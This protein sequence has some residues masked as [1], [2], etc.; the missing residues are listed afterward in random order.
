MTSR[1][2]PPPASLWADLGEAARRSAQYGIDPTSPQLTSFSDLSEA[3]ERLANLSDPLLQPTLQQILDANI[4]VVL[5]DH[6]GNIALCAA[7]SRPV[8]NAMDT[9]ALAVGYS[10]AEDKVGTNGV[11]TSLATKQPAMVVGG[12]HYLEAFKRFS[13]AHAP[14]FDPVSRRVI[15]SVGLVCPVAETN[16]FLLPTAFQL[17]QSIQEQLL[18]E[19]SPDERVLLQSF[20]R[21]RRNRTVA[22]LAINRKTWIATPT[23]QA[24]LADHDHVS[25]WSHLEQALETR[26]PVEIAG[27]E[28]RLIQLHVR[29]VVGHEAVVLGVVE[30]EDS[31]RVECEAFARQGELPNMVGQSAAWQHV[32][33][34]SHSASRLRQPL[35]ITGEFG[36][37]RSTVAKAIAHI[38]G[39][40]YDAF[41]AS[42]VAIE[43]ATAWLARIAQALAQPQVVIIR[44]LDLLEDSAL[45]AITSIVRGGPAGRLIATV[46]SAA[47]GSEP[48]RR[49]RS[50]V[51]LSIDV[52]ALRARPNDIEPIA[53]RHLAAAGRVAVSQRFFEALRRRPGTG[54]V[55]G[56]LATLDSAL[57]S[58]RHGPL[59]I[60][61]LPAAPTGSSA[62]LTG[63]IQ[64]AEEA[65]IRRALAEA[66]GNRTVAAELLGFSRATLYRRL[67]TYG[68]E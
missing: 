23:A 18:A 16:P 35:T 61:H 57:D 58:A 9:H 56:L 65:A 20:L 40:P 31:R 59:T 7:G 33:R 66:D 28:G 36:S 19:A 43:G 48:E 12:E 64:R 60:E 51:P 27:R 1:H 67:R 6:R 29:E 8:R 68:L 37:G 47:P 3:A 11:G 5:A 53:R 52:P 2:N 42:A 4:G 26:A 17:A 55:T 15:G 50:I 46:A 45:L 38:S 14:V 22:L 10:L 54:N 32:V 25:L 41:D 30:R 24:I 21:H 63:G 49:F 62:P 39:M 13:C 44:D 34:Q